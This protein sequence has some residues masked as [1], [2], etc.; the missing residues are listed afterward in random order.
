MSINLKEVDRACS[1][2]IWTRRH[3]RLPAR[4]GCG[5]HRTDRTR[6]CARGSGHRSGRASNRGR[7]AAAQ[8]CLPRAASTSSAASTAT[9]TTGAAGTSSTAAESRKTTASGTTIAP[10]AKPTVSR[11]MILHFSLD[12]AAGKWSFVVLI[13]MAVDGASREP[14]CQIWILPAR[15]NLARRSAMSNSGS[16]DCVTQLLRAH[17]STSVSVMERI[18]HPGPSARSRRVD[19]DASDDRESGRPAQRAERHSTRRRCRHVLC[20]H[21]GPPRCSRIC[22][23]A[24]HPGW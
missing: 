18:R 9:A 5:H 15:R 16:Q 2:T 6:A 21:H 19:L 22:Q 3:R 4:A 11:R 13:D 7:P 10:T 8:A 12:R 23:D 1:Q 24:S 14:R 20:G 17:R